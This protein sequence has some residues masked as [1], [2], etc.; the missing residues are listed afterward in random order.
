[1]LRIAAL[2]VVAVLSLLLLT[3]SATAQQ[4]SSTCGCLHGSYLREG[5]GM[6]SSDGKVPVRVIT[7]LEVEGGNGSVGVK[8]RVRVEPVKE[9]V[10]VGITYTPPFIDLIAYTDRGVLRWSE[11][12][13]FIQALHHVNLPYEEGLAWEVPAGCVKGVTVV[14]KA[15]GYKVTI[16][17]SQAGQPFNV[18][19]KLV[20]RGANTSTYRVVVGPLAARGP[21]GI[22]VVKAELTVE[23]PAH[24]TEGEVR[25]AVT[26]YVRGVGSVNITPTGTPLRIA[27]VSGG[28]EGAV[29]SSKAGTKEFKEVPRPTTRAVTLSVTRPTTTKPSSIAELAESTSTTPPSP[30]IKASPITKSLVGTPTS[31]TPLGRAGGPAPVLRPGALAVALAVAVAL[32]AAAYAALTRV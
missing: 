4:P 29:A 26:E 8:V 31:T 23:A 16:G 11:G 24:L 17:S 7:R 18:T 5:Y 27:G 32:G 13:F 14:V 25:E 20:R 1:M 6:V 10:N 21:K 9:G 30:S 22:K 19:V 3:Y 12:R 15:V 28:Y 2:A